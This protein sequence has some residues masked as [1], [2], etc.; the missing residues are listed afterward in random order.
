[1]DL[2]N[3][4]FEKKKYISK[5]LRT[6]SI[7]V[8]ASSDTPVRK[9]EAEEY[10][11]EVKRLEEELNKR[12][13]ELLEDWEGELISAYENAK[14]QEEEYVEK[15]KKL[16]EEIVE[17]RE[18]EKEALEEAA[19]AA[20]DAVQKIRR[21]SM[22]D[23]QIAMDKLREANKK[24]KEAR[25]L[26]AEGTVESLKQAQKLY[27]ETMDIY[28]DLGS[29]EADSEEAIMSKAAAIN[30]VHNLEKKLVKTIQKE[31]D[32]QEENKRKEI[33][34]QKELLSKTE[35]FTA[36]IEDRLE[37][38]RDRLEDIEKQQLST[39]KLQIESN[40]D[41]VYDKA[42]NLVRYLKQQ[43]DGKTYTYTVQEKRVQAHQAGGFIQRTK[44]KAKTLSTGGFLPGYGGGDKIK[45]LLES[46]EFV[47][48]KESVQRYGRSFF[49]MLNSSIA[50]PKDIQLPIPK[51]REG[52]FVGA[53][54][55]NSD[56]NLAD[57]GKMEIVF[58]NKNYPI[59]GKQDVLNDLQKDL[60][61]QKMVR[62]NN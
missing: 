38:V 52:G 35:Q 51:M 6:T 60:A 18:E 9:R 62:R 19:Q 43:V 4:E 11:E 26:V 17:I 34:K 20:E 32:L 47:V 58:E 48:N 21:S 33:D 2:L 1:M 49:E 56:M 3:R 7:I 27:K 8:D 44:E 39:K 22:T 42:K 24:E 5:K 40:I 36:K 16:K 29:A 54:A 12:K 15:I 45:A 10:V 14:E 25:E 41:K 46:G 28:T 57:F 13:I 31:K 53:G 23:K 55:N 61:K 30:Y 50:N 37:T 59:M